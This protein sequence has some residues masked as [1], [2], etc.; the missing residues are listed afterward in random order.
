MASDQ[1]SST[2]CRD[3]KIQLKPTVEPS[4]NNTCVF[5]GNDVQSFPEP[6][7]GHEKSKEDCMELVAD[8]KKEMQQTKVHAR[9]LV[10]I[11][12]LVYLLLLKVTNTKNMGSKMN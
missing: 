7:R 3:A 4:W 12:I 8:F 9:H 5:L 10:Q 2:L 11:E 1:P 6:L